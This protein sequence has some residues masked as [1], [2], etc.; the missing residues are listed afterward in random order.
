M[1]L[2]KFICFRIEPLYLFIYLFS[3]GL[4]L[5]IMPFDILEANLCCH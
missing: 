2:L 5:D 3:D 4:Y 1:V